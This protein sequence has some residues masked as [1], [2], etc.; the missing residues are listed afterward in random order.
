M[1]FLRGDTDIHLN[2]C[3]V[4]GNLHWGGNTIGSHMF[5]NGIFVCS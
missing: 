5:C 1:G 2:D 3:I 4:H